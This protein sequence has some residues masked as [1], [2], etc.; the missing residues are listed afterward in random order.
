MRQDKD[1]ESS[2][3]TLSLGGMRNQGCKCRLGGGFRLRG[4]AKNPPASRCLSVN[5]VRDAF[6]LTG[7]LCGNPNLLPRK[8][9]C[10]PLWPLCSKGL[11]PFPRWEM[12]GQYWIT[13]EWIMESQ[14]H[15][16]EWLIESQNDLEELKQDQKDFWA[17]NVETGGSVWAE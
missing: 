14:N 5:M 11:T 12:S 2:C 10:E 8:R 9:P 6:C 15:R 7:R 13:A 17:W 16:M 3:K 1:R 4:R